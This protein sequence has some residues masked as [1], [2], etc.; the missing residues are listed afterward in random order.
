MDGT[1][2]VVQPLTA[3]EHMLVDYTMVNQNNLTRVLVALDRGIQQI[4]K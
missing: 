4:A 2:V 1:R 3:T